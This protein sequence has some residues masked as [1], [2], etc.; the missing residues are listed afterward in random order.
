MQN[1]SSVDVQNHISFGVLSNDG[2]ADV[3]MLCLF[4][5]DCLHS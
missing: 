1:V 4:N 2:V 3:F 5:V